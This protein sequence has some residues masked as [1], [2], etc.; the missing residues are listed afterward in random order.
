MELAKS[1]DDMY[2]ENEERMKRI[3]DKLDGMKNYEKDFPK[4]F[5]KN[6]EERN[7]KR[8]AIGKRLMERLKREYK[9]NKK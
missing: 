5:E 8:P 6:D 4:A 1:A 7:N 2:A 9:K 3:K